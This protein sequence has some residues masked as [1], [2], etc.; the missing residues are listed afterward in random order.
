MAQT[1]PPLSLMFD[2]PE[3]I[4]DAN[5]QLAAYMTQLLT[6]AHGK[7]H[8]FRLQMTFE[9]G[10]IVVRGLDVEIDHEK[11]VARLRGRIR[12]EDGNLYIPSWNVFLDF[13]RQRGV[14]VKV[15]GCNA[16]WINSVVS[17]AD[18]TVHEG[19]TGELVVFDGDNGTE[20]AFLFLLRDWAP[21]DEAYEAGEHIHE[22]AGT[23]HPILAAAALI[24]VRQGVTD[25]A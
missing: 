6:E 24:G 20:P 4:R 25:V 23:E 19:H 17:V 2:I 11:L 13:L 14:E 8:A 15:E 7:A 18:E 5:D 3:S 10:F 12:M 21:S 22:V 9:D 16:D 1:L